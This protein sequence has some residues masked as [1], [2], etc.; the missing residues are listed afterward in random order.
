VKKNRES[1]KR[2]LVVA[3]EEETTLKAGAESRGV[4]DDPCL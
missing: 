2:S 1:R 4:E 3:T